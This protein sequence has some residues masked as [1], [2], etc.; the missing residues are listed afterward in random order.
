MKLRDLTVSEATNY[1]SRLF[2]SDPIL[3]ACSVIGELSGMK[4]YPSGHVYFSVVDAHSKLP[5][6]MFRS[7]AE[8]FADLRLRDGDRVKL[9]GRIAVY[10]REGRYQM[11]CH[12]IE[13]DGDGDLFQ[14]FLLL[15]AELSKRGY[16]D[17]ERKKRLPKIRRVGV[18]TSRVG[19]AIEDFTSI[20]KRR[21][22]TIE[23]DLYPSLVQG[24]EAAAQLVAGIAYFN[25]AKSVDAIVITRGGGS[26]EDLSCFND[27]DLATAIYQSGLPIV[28]AVGH[29]TDF[30]IADFVADL[31]AP[32][33]SAA[34]ELISPPLA[35]LE[36][37][38]KRVL[39]DMNGVLNNRIEL[40]KAQLK[41]NHPINLL[42]AVRRLVEYNK[43]QVGTTFDRAGLAIEATLSAKRQSA[44]QM[45][46]TVFLQN[47]KRLLT[48]G[49]CYAKDSN[50][51][52]I[53]TVQAVEQGDDI[54]LILSDGALISTVK[55]VIK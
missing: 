28:S 38:M 33:P 17:Q 23:I 34:A 3:N 35:E 32:T 46:K 13:R 44:E 16:F 31:R 52:L 39:S 6:V 8:R 22:R 19:A 9:N 26:I 30:T 43:L 1:I 11:I 12:G 41:N 37:E 15:K 55:E 29:E 10:Q 20:L 24:R 53:S 5:C 40:F 4:R 54:S 42:S 2:S 47:P 7:D 27:E 25:R 50:G 18:I 14:K 51:K 49:Y 45:Y 36:R 48:R 21:D